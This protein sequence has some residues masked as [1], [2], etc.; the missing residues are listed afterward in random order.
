MIYSFF[1]HSLEAFIV[2]IQVFTSS[3]EFSAYSVMQ[4]ISQNCPMKNSWC[5]VQSIWHPFKTMSS[6]RRLKLSNFELS[7]STDGICQYL[8]LI[9]SFMKMFQ[10]GNFV[11]I[12]PVFRRWWWWCW[13]TLF[14]LD[15]SRQILNVLFL[16]S[17]Q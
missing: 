2:W 10:L 17:W 8:Q 4:I 12:L 1:K 16:V 6:K 7:V 5:T 15:G 14:I 3:W 9:P 13:V 11:Q